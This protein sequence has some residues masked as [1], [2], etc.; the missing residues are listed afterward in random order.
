MD[1]LRGGNPGWSVPDDEKQ[2]RKAFK[3]MVKATSEEVRKP[4]LRTWAGIV[5]KTT[6]KIQR[7]CEEVFEMECDARE[8]ESILYGDIQRLLVFRRLPM[9]RPELLRYLLDL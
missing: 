6:A 8:A 2:I 4:L 1:P 5:K 3:I 9:D 7:K